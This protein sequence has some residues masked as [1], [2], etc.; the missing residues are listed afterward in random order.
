M[1]S[2]LQLSQLA[3][4]AGGHL[5]GVDVAIAGVSTDTRSIRPGDVYFCL[6]GERFDGHD[7]AHGALEKGA[8]A[9]VVESPIE[10][11]ATQLI[12]PDCREAFGLL[13]RLWRRSMQATVIGVT[14]SNGKTT[15]KQML[16]SVCA[17]ACVDPD[18]VHYTHA[19]D[20][21]DIGVPQTLLGIRAHHRYAV[22]EMGANLRGEIAW[23]GK[24]VEPDIAMITNVSESHLEGFGQLQDVA[25]EKSCIYDAL[26]DS[27]VAVVNC[28]DAFAEDW[29]RQNKN[30]K[31]VTFGWKKPA[32]VQV[33]QSE[34]LQLAL[35][36]KG[37]KV[38][39]R[40][41]LAGAHNA[42]NAAA[43]AAVAQALELADDV[44]V[45]GL[46]ST[47]PVKGRLNFH[48][49]P[50]GLTIIDDTYNANPASTRAAIDVLVES[51]GMR[52]LVLADLRELGHDAAQMHESVGQYALQ[53]GVDAV[54][55][56]GA[57][58]RSTVDAFGKDGRWFPSRD[59]LM[60]ELRLRDLSNTTLLVKGSRS[61]QMNLLVD[62]LLDPSAVPEVGGGALT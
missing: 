28:D 61:M 54:Y 49:L 10:G 37:R 48:S 2:K 56:T 35:D 1:N 29:L 8:V 17:A 14:G 47:Q 19:N 12:V 7:Y 5:E 53:M 62:E 44:L 21:N 33:L 24:I 58:T 40:L 39:A 25:A 41:Q 15:V 50:S 60:G 13:A 43:V 51:V 6:R 46:Q 27:G 9:I 32:D 16:A 20:N 11:D 59:E 30:R 36:V 22:I 18:E 34:T 26:G 45:D 57:L 4:V 31:V 52:L 42:M 55:A 38:S 23:L 3:R